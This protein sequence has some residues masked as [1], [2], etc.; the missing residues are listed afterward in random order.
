[1]VIGLYQPELKA[2][3]VSLSELLSN[4]GGTHFTMKVF[5]ILRSPQ[6]NI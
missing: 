1:M 2:L 5:D 4:N 6:L 3:P